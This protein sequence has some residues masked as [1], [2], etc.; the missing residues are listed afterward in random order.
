MKEVPQKSWYKKSGEKMSRKCRE[1][2]IIREQKNYVKSN[3]KQRGEILD[4][5]ERQTGLSRKRLNMLILYLSQSH[6]KC[7]ESRGKSLYYDEKVGEVIK[8]ITKYYQFLCAENLSVCLIDRTN[9]LIKLG[10]INISQETYQKLKIISISSIKRLY[11]RYNISPE[12]RK[13]PSVTRKILTGIELCVANKEKRNERYIEC[14]SVHHSGHNSRGEF[15]RTFVFVDVETGMIKMRSCLGAITPRVNSCILHNIQHFP[16]KIKYANTDNGSEFMNYPVQKTF[17]DHGIQTL[18]TRPYK[19]N[20]NAHV[21]NRN[22][23]YV[24]LIVGHIRYDTEI[25][26]QLLNRIFE[27][28]C[29]LINY[30]RPSRNIIS[31]VYNS[32][33]GKYIKRY[34]LPETPYQRMLKSPKITKSEKVKVI[35]IKN[36][37]CEFSLCQDLKRLLHEL[38]K[39]VP[40]LKC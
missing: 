7:K 24:R 30:F 1:E 28:E 20:D 32:S 29:H 2:L 13:K 25:Q 11:K 10:I 4:I 17:A 35:K 34:S 14:D 38:S 26:V 19:K 5:L 36:S 8:T 23:N 3:K 18:R 6:K 39:T 12:N 31:N 15:A 27:I 40:L 37:L 9:Q 22:R 33:T 16:Y 21:E